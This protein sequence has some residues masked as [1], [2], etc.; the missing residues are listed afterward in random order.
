MTNPKPYIIHGDV[1]KKNLSQP[2]EKSDTDLLSGPRKPV[3]KPPTNNVKHGYWSVSFIAQVHWGD[4]LRLRHG[5]ARDLG[6]KS[7]IETE[8]LDI[9]AYIILRQGLAAEGQTMP[10]GSDDVLAKSMATFCKCL[11]TLREHR[12]SQAVEDKEN[13]GASKSFKPSM[14]ERAAE[15][16]SR[17]GIVDE[18]KKKEINDQVDGA[19]ERR[20][21]LPQLAGYAEIIDRVTGEL[22]PEPDP[23]LPARS[24]TFRTT[25]S[26]AGA[27]E[28]ETVWSKVLDARQKQE[29]DVG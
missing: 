27:I 14:A 28:Q 5:L 2:R 3:A 15:I 1:A 29:K 24:S 10:P 7:G 22:P 18:E 8:L 21:S 17:E 20:H 9:M 12:K 23:T 25:G 19:M 16:L 6:E 4:F 11:E 26:R 13:K